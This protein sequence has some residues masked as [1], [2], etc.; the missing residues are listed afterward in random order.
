MN[1]MKRICV[2]LA[3][4]FEEIEAIAVI[5]ILRRGGLEVITVSINDEKTVTGAHNIQV[6]ADEIISDINYNIID[7]IVLPGGMPGTLNLGSNET[8]CKQIKKFSTGR[9]IAAICAAPSVLG[10]LGVLNG[11]DA[12]CY[13]G[14]E[15]KL[16]GA[17]I[18]TDKNVVVSDNIITAKG[19]RAAD[20]FAFE[21]LRMFDVDDEKINEL[22]AGMIYK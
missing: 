21:I 19:P 15:S 4:G 20:E 2:H 12:T 17:N 10:N 6:V 22:K 3:E 18:I 16:I 8:L 13:P 14:F 1:M 9:L 5:D 11:K 7:M